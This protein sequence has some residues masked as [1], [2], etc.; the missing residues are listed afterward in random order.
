MKILN[1]EWT[2][3]IV[4]NKRNW[5]DYNSD[6]YNKC[7]ELFKVFHICFLSLWKFTNLQ[8]INIGFVNYNK[9]KGNYKTTRN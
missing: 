7:E 9:W 5:G 4:E 2:T 3:D 1:E 6:K 8:T